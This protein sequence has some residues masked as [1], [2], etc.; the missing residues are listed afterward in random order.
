VLQNLEDASLEFRHRPAARTLAE[1]IASHAASRPRSLAI[2]IEDRKPLTYRALAQQVERV[3]SALRSAGIG[4]KNRVAIAMPDGGD[5]AI[6]IAAVACHATVVPLNPRLTAAEIDALFASH[7]LDAIVLPE[8]AELPARSVA[9]ERGA[10]LLEASPGENGIELQLKTPPLSKSG[11]A[12]TV[13]LDDVVMILRTSGTT[14]KPK[15]VPITHRYL[16]VMAAQRRHWFGLGPKDRALAAVPV[17]YSQGSNILFASLMVGASLA[18]PSR[19]SGSSFCDWLAGLE[20]TWYSAGPT[21]HRTVLD[22]A[23]ARPKE[24]LRH[25][26]RFIQSGA[27]PLPEAVQS[28]LEGVFGVPVCSS[29]GMTETGN[30]TANALGADG[31][32]RGTVG[33]AY[34][35]EVA[36][37]QEDG[38]ILT[39]GGPAEILVRGPSVTPG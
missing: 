25:K 20:P 9:T 12:E 7:R 6:T 29:Y 37:R 17:Y 4:A 32:R 15:L 18:C 14:A 3:G 39:R 28:G 23:L 30:I 19:A 38:V 10:C 2:V 26:L 24:E 27:A 16:D 33:K 22:Q 31:R 8:G 36:L 34:G 13:A 5:L 11:A 21:F 1:A 35:I